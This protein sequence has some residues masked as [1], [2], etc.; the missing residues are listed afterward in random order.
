MKRV[1]FQKTVL[2]VLFA[3]AGCDKASELTQA[4]APESAESLVAADGV[5]NQG[6]AGALLIE[7]RLIRTATGR[8]E[9]RDLDAAVTSLGELVRRVNG[10]V[11]ESDISADPENRSATFLARIPS[12]SLNSLID[13]LASLGKVRAIS[14]SAVDVSREYFD[15]ETRLAVKEA[16][17]RRLTQLIER[18]SR[19]E[20]V[21][22][23]ER[24]LAR[25][26][27]ELESLKGQITYFDRKT[28]EA[29]LRLHLVESGRGFGG[30]TIRPVTRAFRNATN[31]LANS[32]ASLVYFITF[33]LPWLALALLLWLAGRRLLRR[34]PRAQERLYPEPSA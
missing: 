23:V 31:V 10:V 29:E 26:T 21:V 34:R 19:V 11:A 9:V 2:I 33:A 25:A 20:D 1:R 4:S 24:E 16:S 6:Q 15:I 32:F 5:V 12:D 3:L 27:A 22:A 18:A 17:V 28:A 8:I 13:R 14:T 30:A 7:P